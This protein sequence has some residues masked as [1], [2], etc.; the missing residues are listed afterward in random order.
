MLDKH[1][2]LSAKDMNTATIVATYLTREV[3]QNFP[4]TITDTFYNSSHLFSNTLDTNWFLFVKMCS[5]CLGIVKI[6]KT[7]ITQH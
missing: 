1:C 2:K 6:T 4:K 3:R 5:P 7:V